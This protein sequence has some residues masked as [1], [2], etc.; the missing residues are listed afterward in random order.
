[1]CIRD[2]GST[3]SQDLVVETQSDSNESIPRTPPENDELSVPAVSNEAQPIAYD[4]LAN[5]P[6]VAF[7]IPSDD[8][9]SNFIGDIEATQIDEVA[10]ATGKSLF[11]GVQGD[12]SVSFLDQSIGMSDDS[13]RSNNSSLR[14]ERTIEV[15]VEPSLA[16]T[17][18]G[19]RESLSE[20]SS[21]ELSLNF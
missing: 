15:T 11:S 1:M 18:F 20:T 21:G 13:E 4:D 5:K 19:G 7:N 9:D 3:A 12:D 2:R 10:A 16:Q 17:M 14:Q 8:E 6:R